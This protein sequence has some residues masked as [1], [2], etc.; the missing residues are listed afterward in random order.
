MHCIPSDIHSLALS[1][2]FAFLDVSDVNHLMSSFPNL[3]ITPRMRVVLPMSDDMLQDA[4]TALRS[5]QTG[6]KRVH[7]LQLDE[8][9]LTDAC[10]QQQRILTIAK[11]DLR[12]TP[13]LAL[14]PSPGWK[15]E[16]RSVSN[17]WRRV[18]TIAVIVPR[19]EPWEGDTFIEKAKEVVQCNLALTENRDVATGAIKIG[20][21]RQN[22][23]QR[24][25]S[26]QRREDD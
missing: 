10:L 16:L 14:N 24:V 12:V 4:E 11:E 21:W 2:R 5:I 7:T 3:R 20:H 8:L 22:I 15:K 17:R 25:I 6:W 9:L 23:A 18:H 19:T 13:R 26:V 1:H